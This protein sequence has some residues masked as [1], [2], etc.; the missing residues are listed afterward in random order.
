MLCGKTGLGKI[1]LI[2]SFVTENIIFHKQILKTFI[3]HLTYFLS[4]NTNFSK[5][6]RF[7]WI[8]AYYSNKTFFL[9]HFFLIILGI[10]KLI[11]KNWIHSSCTESSFC[12]NK[13]SIIKLLIFKILLFTL[14]KQCVLM[15]R[16]HIWYTV[17][18]KSCLNQ[19][20]VQIKFLFT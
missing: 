1:Y 16:T 11:L 6:I 12:E 15:K 5:M 9:K 13:L 20:L 7:L 17:K 18:Q 10:A 14:W 3:S 2:I 8:R 19:M 4:L